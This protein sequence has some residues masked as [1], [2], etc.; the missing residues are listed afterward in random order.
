MFSESYN[1]KQDEMNAE[2]FTHI[3]KQ[4][5]Q[6]LH[7]GVTPEAHIALAAHMIAIAIESIEM[8]QNNMAWSEKVDSRKVVMDMVE[9]MVTVQQT[10]L[11][12]RKASIEGAN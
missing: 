5:Q 10:Q 7:D 4:L 12:A 1:E 6:S 9:G 3:A 2:F 11:K 8:V